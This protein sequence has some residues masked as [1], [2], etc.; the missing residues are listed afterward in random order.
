MKLK[1]FISAYACEPNLGSE[2]GVGW[3]WVLEMSK[4]F[5]V[6]VL[7]RET[8][9]HTIEPWV[10]KYPEYNHIKFL[11][12]DLPRWSRF[13]K[14]GLRG[15]HIYYLLWQWKI[16]NL[17]K[18]TMQENDI[19]IFHHLTYGNFLWPVSKY[20]QKQF[21]VW[22]PGSTGSIVPKDFSRKY[23]F[24]GRIKEILQ[25]SIRK[26]LRYNRRFKKQ[27]RNSDLIL[28]KTNDAYSCIP[29]EDTNKAVL[30]TDVATVATVNKVHS[31]S[32][33]ISGQ[34]IN[35]FAAGRLEGWRGF[36]IL[37][38]SLVRAIEIYPHLKLEIAGIGN[39][40]NKLQSLIDRLNMHDHI[41]L[42][43]EIPI[44]TYHSKMAEADVIVNPCLREGGVTIAFDSMSYGKPLICIDTGGYT[45]YFD[46]SYAEVIA[47]STREETI[48]HMKKA[49]L[50][51]TDH[52]ARE[53]KGL[54]AK[55]M[56]ENYTWE[57]KGQ[58]IYKTISQAYSEWVREKK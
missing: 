25:R 55:V 28:C 45:R 54:K 15:V 21:F 4:Y 44:N 46:N 48:D 49:I 53:A 7:T 8:N 37:I 29:F 33:D 24:T 32:N 9:R 12:Y 6:W 40:W 39:E 47:L 2:I 19:D 17:V 13:W 23:S 51:L 57:E 11:Y 5:D 42:L 35:L 58:Q 38:E 41:R 22:G 1:I 10:S 20:G 3:H 16:N 56:A 52:D 18:L 36:D 27:C 30:F 31:V 14:K 26:T 43:G 34:Y 50:R